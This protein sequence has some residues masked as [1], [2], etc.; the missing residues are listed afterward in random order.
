MRASQD[1]MC[2]TTL[3]WIPSGYDAVLYAEASMQIPECTYNIVDSPMTQAV[4]RV[5]RFAGGYFLIGAADIHI[6][7]L[8]SSVLADAPGCIPMLFN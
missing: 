6:L 1:N 7:I 4:K 5:L 2:G 3:P 8:I